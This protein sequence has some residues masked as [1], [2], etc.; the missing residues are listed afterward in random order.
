MSKSVILVF[1]LKIFFFEK[2][3]EFKKRKNVKII[4][5][6]LVENGLKM[7]KHMNLF[8][9]KKRKKNCK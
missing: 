3:T 6:V 1:K 8:E 7:Q 5:F 2:D 4:C 9:K